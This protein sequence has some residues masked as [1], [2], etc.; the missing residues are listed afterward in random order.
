MI[1]HF[2]YGEASGNYSLLKKQKTNKQKKKQSTMK[3]LSSF[4]FIRGIRVT[5]VLREKAFYNLLKSF[6]DYCHTL[7]YIYL[8]LKVWESGWYF[9]LHLFVCLLLY[10]YF[11]K[12]NFFYPCYFTHFVLF[13]FFFFNKRKS[14]I[15]SCMRNIFLTMCTHTFCTLYPQNSHGGEKK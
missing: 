13:F 3:M 14:S 12:Y 2:Y 9:T 8:F 1:I 4:C 15:P 6:W 7:L 10:A 11:K 5:K